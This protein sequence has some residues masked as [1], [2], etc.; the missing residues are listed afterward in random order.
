MIRGAGLRSRG[1][2]EIDDGFGFLDPPATRRYGCLGNLLFHGSARAGRVAGRRPFHLP[3][4][5]SERSATSVELLDTPTL[6]G[7]IA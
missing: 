2:V 3:T 6:N 7:H 5:E 4:P 1:R